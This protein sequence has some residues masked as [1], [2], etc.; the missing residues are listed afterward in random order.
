M[1]DLKQL[2]LEQAIT[3]SVIK[4]GSSEVQT[5]L[6]RALEKAKEFHPVTK[7]YVDGYTGEISRYK[8]PDNYV[9]DDGVVNDKPD[10]CHTEDHVSIAQMYE[11]LKNM[12]ALSLQA[13]EGWDFSEGDVSADDLD[14]DTIDDVVSEVDDPSDYDN[15]VNDMID[16]RLGASSHQQANDS[17][18]Q[19][20]ALESKNENE[21]TEVAEAE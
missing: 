13:S 19:K 12:K 7:M 21:A 6:Q 3:E 16:E 11:R 18:G 9:P 14:E 1:V 10:L 2:D 20:S 15:Y 5:E 8:T 17:A 4:E